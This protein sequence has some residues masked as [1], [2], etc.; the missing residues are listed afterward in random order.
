MP[1]SPSLSSRAIIGKF[2]KRL[3]AAYDAGWAQKLLMRFSS[4]QASETY[5]WLGQVPAMRAWG[6]GRL[7]KELRSAGITIPNVVYES[8]LNISVDDMRRDKTG[9]INVRINELAARAAQHPE[10]LLA[11]LIGNGTGS[12]SGLAYDGQYFFDDDHTEGD[13]GTQKNLLTSSEVSQLNVATATA[14]TPAEMSAA[15]LGVIGHMLTFKDDQGEPLNGDA[16]QF[17]V[18]TAHPQIYA[19]AMAACTQM[20]LQAGSGAVQPN[21]LLSAGFSVGCVLNAHLTPSSYTDDFWVFR[22]DGDVRPFILQEEQPV[23]IDALAEGSELEVN[24]RRHQYGV[25]AIH[26]AGYGMWQHAAKATL[27]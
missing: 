9:Q 1:Y 25:T 20:Q 4:D 7:V 26:G 23:R 11:T 14:P 15:I 22:T 6:T 24:E 21:V 10:S 17:L 16:R 3:K 19:P 18:M 8:T 5:N 27:S 12:T 2:Y 13:S